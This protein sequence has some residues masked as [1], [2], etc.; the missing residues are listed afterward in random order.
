LTNF[1]TVHGQANVAN[2][3]KKNPLTVPAQGL[4]N[5][6]LPTAA[7]VPIQKTSHAVKKT[8]TCMIDASMTARKPDGDRGKNSDDQAFRRVL[9]LRERS[10]ISFGTHDI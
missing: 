9:S 8:T 3:A 2:I 6:M 10:R 7:P 4:P 1:G 5:A